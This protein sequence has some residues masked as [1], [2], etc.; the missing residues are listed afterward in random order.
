[1]ISKKYF[2]IIILFSFI[3]SLNYSQGTIKRTLFQSSPIVALLNGV[4][5]DNFTV[6]EIIKNGDFG[7]GTFNGVDGEMIVLDVKVF[8]VDNNGK[9]TVP[10]KLTCTPFVSVTFFQCG[11]G[12]NG[13]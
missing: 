12:N 13:K 8:R 10:N 6:G 3:S 7:L 5:N 1:M 2:N 11:Y 4:M 9:I